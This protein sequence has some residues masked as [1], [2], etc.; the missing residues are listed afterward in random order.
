[1]N[2][3]KKGKAGEALVQQHYEQQG[4]SFLE[5]NF[6]IRGGEID[7]LMRKDRMLVA[8]EVKH[9]DTVEELDNYITMKKMGHLQRTLESFLWQ[10]NEGNFGEVRMDAVFVRQGKIIEIYENVTNT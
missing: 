8:V 4:F 5:A 6:A 1:M 10:T 9:L 2:H 3:K 7:L